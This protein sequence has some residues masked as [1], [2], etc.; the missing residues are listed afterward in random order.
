MK[1]AIR[2]FGGLIG[3]GAIAGLGLWL[4]WR[5][6]DIAF[7]A[8][9]K[10]YAGPASRY[11]DLGEGVRLHYRDQGNPNGTPVVLVH[12]FGDN[13]FS[14]DGWAKVLAAKY[15]VLSLDMPGHGLTRTPATFP[16]APDAY[17]DLIDRWAQATGI[18]RFAVAGNS[19]GGG[20]AWQLAL[21]HPARV[22][23]LIL[24]DAAGWP[25]ETLKNPPLAFRLMRYKL[26]RDFITSIDNTP[27]IRAGLL[28][29]VV[30][31]SVVTDAFVKR[32]ADLQRAPGHRTILMSLRPG[33]M[34]ASAPALAKIAVPTLIEWGDAD[35][36]IEVSA[37]R[38]FHDAIPG[39]RLIVYPRVGHLPQIEIPERSATDALRF[40][41]SHP[42]T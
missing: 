20:V 18:A 7:A 41:D 30:D 1:M 16:A 27:L 23:R 31:K 40:L 38:K 19:M 6:P 17:A 3:L 22:D 12:G 8:L 13:A 24:V 14:W 39:S 21:R 33:S 37:A 5:A 10:T 32:W 25:S 15:R 4:Y 29:N 26:G 42:E 9:E 28:N 35:P 36:L 11:A 2:I 34:Q